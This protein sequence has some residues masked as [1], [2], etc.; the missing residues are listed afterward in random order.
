MADE[1]STRV[2]SVVE[3]LLEADVTDQID[4]RGREIRIPIETR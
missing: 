1:V 4:R 3:K 2:R